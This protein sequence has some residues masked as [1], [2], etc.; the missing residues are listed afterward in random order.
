M[1]AALALHDR[2]VRLTLAACCG[3]EV[4]VGAAYMSWPLAGSELALR[5]TEKIAGTAEVSAPPGCIILRRPRPPPLLATP[6]PPQVTT[7]GDAFLVAF[8]EPVDAVR[9]AL[10]LQSALLKLDWPPLLLEH[11][12]CRPR[13]LVPVAGLGKDGAGRDAPLLVLFKGLAV[14]MG[15]ATGV[16]SAVREHP[17]TRRMQYT[18]A[19]LRLA[20]GIA[21]LGCGGQVLL[22][23]MTF[24]GIHNKFEELDVEEIE[25]QELTDLISGQPWGEEEQVGRNSRSLQHQHQLQP[26]QPPIGGRESL[27]LSEHN[28][29]SYSPAGAPG[30]NSTGG[31]TG[32]SSYGVYGSGPA[33]TGGPGGP[34]SAGRGAAA[35]GGGGGAGGGGGPGSTMG[36]SAA[37]SAPGSAVEGDYLSSATSSPALH[38]PHPHAPPQ[39]MPQQ[40]HHHH[41]LQN[42][43]HHYPVH[44][45]HPHPHQALNQ[46]PYM[47]PH[48][49][50]QHAQHPQHLQHVHAQLHTHSYPHLHP[51]QQPRPSRDAAATA[52]V[53]GA[54]A[55][56][57]SGG[58]PVHRGRSAIALG[59]DDVVFLPPGAC[60]TQQSIPRQH[61]NRM[62]TLAG[63]PS[64]TGA[65]A[66]TGGHT[67]GS[68]LLSPPHGPTLAST[69]TGST[70]VS[71][72][73]ALIE[74]SAWEAVAAAVPST[75]AAPGVGRTSGNRVSGGRRS[76]GNRAS[77]ERDAASRGF[78][79][80][81][82]S[83][84]GGPPLFSAPLPSS[85]V[86]GLHSA[87]SQ[88][89]GSAGKLPLLLQSVAAS[90]AL[91]APADGA[92]GA[93]APSREPTAR[94]SGFVPGGGGGGGSTSSAG[95]SLA[96]GSSVGVFAGLGPGSSLVPPSPTA[97]Y[98]QQVM[99][100][101]QLQNQTQAL[102]QQQQQQQQYQQ[103]Q[104]YQQL[105]Q[106]YQQPQ[107]QPQ[108]YQQQYLQ[109]GPGP[110]LEPALGQGHGQGRMPTQVQVPGQS[111]AQWEGHALE[112]GASSGAGVAVSA[113]FQRQLLSTQGAGPNM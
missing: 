96:L 7:E 82:I 56:A 6:L 81:S 11:S 57:P 89:T 99:N 60:R 8:H 14:R 107:Q 64:V 74:R 50:S 1:N 66:S 29:G 26:L 91:H 75:M 28:A 54:A 21:E 45:Q 98:L 59:Q 37:R 48:P 41:H 5:D 92:G 9:W 32:L 46:H 47:Y 95:F 58:P 2:T 52:P 84:G 104:Q 105:L 49:A 83:N 93:G 79:G 40:Q 31:G 10:L 106:Q 112:P 15:I 103:Y 69:A 44:H 42:P 30:H 109:E 27:V 34:G 77:A 43:P 23:P 3:Y 20:T 19:V 113:A 67:D 53:A 90:Q 72:G 55:A 101:V 12:L 18:G 78:A 86:D 33:A 22:E 88:T 102:V 51:H 80:P 76:S 13:P 97:P 87:P 73:L 4:G 62:L 71:P 25:V 39:P 108:Q 61:S 111:S 38:Q 94:A 17:V 36:P 65:R 35:G 85:V 24:K 100:Q 68:G 16:P 63:R 110:N 70:T